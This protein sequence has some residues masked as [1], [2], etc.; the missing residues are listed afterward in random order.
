MSPNELPILL[1]TANVGSIFE[2]PTNL[3]QQWMVQVY[4]KIRA[5][6]PAFIGIHLQEVG[7]KNFKKHMKNL[8][9]FVNELCAF[10]TDLGFKRSIIFIDKDFANY[11]QFTALGSIYFVHET[12]TNT[13]EIYDWHAHSFLHVT[14]FCQQYLSNIED[15]PLIE[16]HKFPLEYFPKKKASRKGYLRTRWKFSSE[17][18]IDMVNIHLFNDNSNLTSMDSTYPSVYA[19][20]RKRALDYVI[21]RISNKLNGTTTTT[22]PNHNF[23]IFGDFNFRLDNQSVV[24]TITSELEEII[25][26]DNGVK[27]NVRYLEKGSQEIVLSIGKKEFILRSEENT[28]REEWQK[29]THFDKEVDELKDSVAEY[30]LAFPPPYPFSEDSKTTSYMKTRCP[31]WCDRVLMSNELKSKLIKNSE[32]VLYDIIG[33]EV[34]MGDHKPVFLKCHLKLT[35]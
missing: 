27:K 29:W 19:H 32:E 11:G 8:D 14:D 9:K 25:K 35:I 6:K 26:S 28:F 1:I 22:N 4:N 18:V 10:V 34:C 17:S 5:Q 2:D 13:V 15:I 30:P 31:A 23:F 7:G 20:H 33:K 16:K 24:E 12:W 21:G 3:F